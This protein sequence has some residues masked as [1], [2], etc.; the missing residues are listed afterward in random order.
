MNNSPRI[1][2]TFNREEKKD[3][4]Q[5]LKGELCVSVKIVN[6]KFKRSHEIHFWL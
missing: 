2:F 3:N 1:Y 5:K 6:M 4:K